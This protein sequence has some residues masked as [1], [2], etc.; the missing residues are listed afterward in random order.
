M[1]KIDLGYGYIEYGGNEIT[2]AST[3]DDPPKIRLA[4]PKFGDSVS[5]GAV[6]FSRLRPDGEQ[7]EMLIIQGTQ[8]ERYRNNPV[9]YSGELTIHI[10]KHNPK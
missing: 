9:D 1:P 7:E 5:L 3:I 6:T 4:T 10:R 2:I 8:D